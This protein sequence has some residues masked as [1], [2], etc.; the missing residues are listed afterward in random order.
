MKSSYFSVTIL[1][2]VIWP[3]EDEGMGE[4][5]VVLKY[6]H[7]CLIF[8]DIILL[9]ISQMVSFK[10]WWNPALRSILIKMKFFT[11]LYLL[12]I[13]LYDQKKMREWG[14]LLGFLGHLNGGS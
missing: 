1:N 11:F 8:F 3:K 6:M 5:I 13:L 14:E 4:L 12:P 7:V 2:I 10:R 9:T